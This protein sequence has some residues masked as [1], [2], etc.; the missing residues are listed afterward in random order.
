VRHPPPW[1]ILAAFAA[2]V[3]AP[4]PWLVPA[5]VIAGLGATAF[6]AALALA[7]MR[8]PRPAAL[9]AAIELGRDRRGRAV[10]IERDELAAHGLILGASGAGKTTTLLRILTE[11]IRAGQPV[12]AIDMKGSPAFARTL[13]DASLAAGRPFKLWTTEGGASWNP[14]QY[15]NPTELKDKL[16]ATERFTEPHYQRAA[17]RYM[18]TVLRVLQAA[19]R[20]RPATLEEVVL[21][22]DPRRLPSLLREL[23]GDQAEPVHDYLAGLTADQHSAIRGMQTRLALITESQ[24]G[25][26]LS[27]SP[28]ADAIDLRVALSGREV[29]LFSLNSSSYGKLA[30]QLGTLVVQDLVSALGRQLADEASGRP[31]PATIAIDEFSGLG[32]DHVVALFARVREAGGGV[33]VATQEMADLERAASG[34]RDQ[35]VGNTAI[36]IIHRQDVP[37]SARMVAQMGGTE[38][39]WEP[40]RPLGGGLFGGGGPPRGFRRQ[41]ERFILDPNEIN[42]LRTGEAAVISKL[43]GEPPRVLRVSPVARREPPSPAGR[44]QP[45]GVTR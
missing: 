13:A 1:L 25:A 15:G 36:K 17:E 44:R 4:V 45:P 24:A 10:R 28:G 14:L 7:R 38:R 21:M 5:V 11:Q 27:P 16:I 19:H 35:I 33:L 3:L 40:L 6:R 26:F 42:T 31:P 12:I 23:P 29:A 43:R 9:G 34:L 30:S 2:V 37:A 32:G 20:D 39:V 22:M 18:Q 41:I 8:E